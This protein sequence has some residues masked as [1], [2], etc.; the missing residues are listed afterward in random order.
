MTGSQIV[1]IRHVSANALEPLLAEETAEFA[2]EL[3]WDFSPSAALV[4]KVAA[5]R[6]LGGAALLDEDGEVL[7]Y[8]YAV[9]EGRKAIV[10]DVYVRPAWRAGNAEA[11]LFLALLQ[12]LIENSG[13]RRVESQLMLMGADSSGGAAAFGASAFVRACPDAYG[14]AW[15]AG[16]GQCVN[17]AQILDPAVGPWLARFGGQGCLRRVCWACRSPF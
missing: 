14:R 13:A 12:A 10:W 17:Q 16:T 2:R 15:S 4:R 7:G 1:D 9:I 3:D 5:Q 11:Q 8:S 6:G